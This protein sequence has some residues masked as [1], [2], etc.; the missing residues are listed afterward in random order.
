MTGYLDRQNWKTIW[1]RSTSQLGCL[2][3]AS[4]CMFWD[5][6]HRRKRWNALGWS[7]RRS[8][9][10]L[11]I[12]AFFNSKQVESSVLGDQNK[13]YTR[14]GRPI[15][16][17]C[18]VVSVY[19]ETNGKIYSL[20]VCVSHPCLSPPGSISESPRQHPRSSVV[21]PS[22]QNL[23]H[24]PFAKS[25]WVESK[26]VFPSLKISRCIVGTYWSTTECLIFW[27]AAQ[28]EL[29]IINK[30]IKKERVEYLLEFA[31]M[32]QSGSEVS[33]DAWHSLFP[34]RKGTSPSASHDIPSSHP[35]HSWPLQRAEAQIP[36]PFNGC[37]L[38]PS[39]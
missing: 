27:G 20:A 5:G 19:Q 30:R 33:E 32:R 2:F 3:L 1:L 16:H 36:G 39:T 4:C 10:C 6:N 34:S 26:P 18:M 31:T 17:S 23:C 14:L 8:F 22:H 11:K 35:V 24:H 28:E 37:L 12:K 21:H 15:N 38:I 7:A 25:M 9:I 29:E 13:K